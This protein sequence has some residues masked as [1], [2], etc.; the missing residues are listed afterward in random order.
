VYKKNENKID[1]LKFV[2][3]MEN[4]IFFIEIQFVVLSS[5]FRFIVPQPSMG[6]IDA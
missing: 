3:G 6:E 5:M 2:S 1:W 4:T